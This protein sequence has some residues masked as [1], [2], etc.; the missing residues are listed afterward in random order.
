MHVLYTYKSLKAADTHAHTYTH[1]HTHIHTHTHTH[2]LLTSKPYPLTALSFM[3]TEISL[4]PLFSPL[5]KVSRRMPSV[6]T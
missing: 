6:V 2:T 4:C 3:T 1:T 5:L